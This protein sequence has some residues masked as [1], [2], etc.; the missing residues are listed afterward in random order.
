MRIA[1]IAAAALLALPAAQVQE[2]QVAPAAATVAAGQTQRLR[3][4]A[5][6]ASGNVIAS[7]VRYI[8][9]SNNVNVARVDSTGSVTA[10]A[11]GTALI[12][13]EA[14]GSGNPAKSGASTVTVRRP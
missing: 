5:Y 12:K 2:V 1:L 6:D 8:W 7:G 9:T 10:V 4:M 14:V 11:P 3:A 13:A